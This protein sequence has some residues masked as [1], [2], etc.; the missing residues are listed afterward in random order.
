MFVLVK[1][2]DMKI[3]LL[4]VTSLFFNFFN[5]Q[6]QNFSYDWH[7]NIAVTG[8]YGSPTYTQSLVKGDTLYLLGETVGADSVDLNPGLTE[9]WIYDESTTGVSKLIF[10]SKYHVSDGS[11]IE[12]MK[13]AEFPTASSGGIYTYDFEIDQT[14]R[15]ILIG[16]SGTSI[17]FDPS[18][19]TAGWYGTTGGGSF[20]AFYYSNG[21]YM[22][23]LEYDNTLSGWTLISALDLRQAVLDDDNNLYLIGNFYGTMDFDFTGSV[24]NYTSLGEHDP[25]V[26]KINMTTQ[27]YEWGVSFGGS[28]VEYCQYAVMANNRIHVYGTF[29]SGTID[30]DPGVGI[31]AHIKPQTHQCTF[32]NQLDTD[33]NQTGGFVLSTNYMYGMSADPQGNIYLLAEA[34]D[35]EVTD[36]NPGLGV[37]NLNT[38]NQYPMGVAKYDNNL[39]FLWARSFSGSGTGHD[40]RTIATTSAYVSVSGYNYDELY[41]ANEANIDT[42]SNPINGEFFIAN[43]KSVSGDLIEYNAFPVIVD[44]YVE[45]TSQVVSENDEIITVGIFQKELDFNTYDMISQIDTTAFYIWDYLYNPFILKL[46]YLGFADLNSQSSNSQMTIYPNPGSSNF[47]IQSDKTISQIQIFDITGKIVFSKSNIEKSLLQVD[48]SNFENGVYIV[49]I[50]DENND[51]ITQKLIKN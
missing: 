25:C 8:G 31:D 39:N 3:R 44:A 15:F 13:L 21:T 7:Q 10:I 19:A 38:D 51:Q 37:H 28:G 49:E 36:M 26:I 4:A 14:G 50:I 45:G 30:L 34:V 29:D 16:Q 23:H 32:V 48:I 42:I 35:G 1:Q 43:L 40:M 27:T 33:G 17:D 18:L 6:A 2:I 11:Y 9:D 47:T 46:N 22:S 5:G 41:L 24:D 20:A 12:S